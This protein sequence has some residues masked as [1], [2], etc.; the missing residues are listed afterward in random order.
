MFVDIFGWLDQ[1]SP[2]P[3][4]LA[5]TCRRACLRRHR[6]ACRLKTTASPD[7]VRQLLLM[8]PLLEHGFVLEAC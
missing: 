1:F 5:G 8:E 7:H 3:P 6:L 2:I 4:E